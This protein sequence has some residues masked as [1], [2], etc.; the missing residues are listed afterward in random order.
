MP[1]ERCQEPSTQHKHEDRQI[2]EYGEIFPLTEILQ[3]DTNSIDNDG[4]D[5]VDKHLGN[6][7]QT[8]RFSV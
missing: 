1:K 8:P 4:D 2:D 6:A 3:W 5:F 7:D